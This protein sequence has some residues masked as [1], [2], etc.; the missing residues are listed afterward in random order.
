VADVNG[1]SIPDLVV[2]NS[3]SSN[4]PGGTVSVL[5]GNGNGSFQPQR[6]FDVG[7][8]PQSVVVADINGDGRPDLVTAN[9]FD[10]T[11][12]VL[13]GT[14]Q[15]LFQG[16]GGAS[17]RT[18]GPFPVGKEPSSVV[19]ADINKDGI[20]DLITANQS[21]N[22]VSVLLGNGDGT[23]KPQVSFPVGAEPYAVAVADLDGDGSLDLVVANYQDGTISVLLG[24][25]NGTFRNLD[26]V[27]VGNGPYAIGIADVNG[28]GTLDLV[29]PNYLDDTVRVLLG[30]GD[31]T[32]QDPD[33]FPVGSGPCAVQ[34]ADVNRDHKPDLLVANKKDG[35]VSVLLNK[36]RDGA[37]KLTFADPRTVLVG[38]MPEDL[39]VVDLNGDGLLDLITA[40]AADDTVSVLQGKGDGS[41]QP[42]RTFTVGSEPLGV[43]VAD[44]NGDGRPDLVT[45]NRNENTLSVLFSNGDDSFQPQHT[46][47]VGSMPD[48]LAVR[49][50]NGDGRPDLI[51]ANAYGDTVSV[52]L[53]GDGSFTPTSDTGGVEVRNTPLQADF[54]GDGLPDRVILDQAGNI[55]FREGQSSQAMPFD[56]PRVISSGNPARD[57]T[58]VHTG[59]GFAI[60]AADA[61]IDTALS[62]PG[63]LIYTLST[64][65]VG[66]GSIDQTT[67]F[68]TDLLP[69]RIAAADLTG[70]GRDDLVVLNALN[71]SITI[72]FQTGSG[73]FGSALTRS[74]DLV[75]ADV[76]FVDVNGDG[77]LDIVVCDQIS[78]DVCVLFNDPTHSFSVSSRFRATPGATATDGFGVTSNALSVS[79]TAGYFTGDQNPDLVVIN[80]GT[81]TISLLPGDAQGGFGA[82]RPAVKTIG[83]AA[84]NLSDKA[85]SVVAG[86]FNHDGILDLAVLMEDLAQVW[87]FT[88]L[89]NGKL[90]P[91]AVLPAGALPTGLSVINDSRTGRLDLLVGNPFGDILQLVGQ[92][93]GTFQPLLSFPT[94]RA[95]LDQTLGPSNQPVFLVADQQHNRVTIQ[96]PITGETRFMAKSLAMAP[97]TTLF[98]PGAVHWFKLEG[99]ASPFP[100]AVVVASGANAVLVY[101]FVQFDSSGQPTFGQTPARY[102]VGTNP[103]SVT[104][105]DLNGDGIPDLVVANEGSD[106]V[107]ILLGALDRKGHWVAL[108]GPRLQSGGA[109]PVATTLL[110]VNNDGIPD[111][112]VTNSQ[113]NTLAILPGRGLG[114]FDDR[115]PQVISVPANVGPPMPTVDPAGRSPLIPTPGGIFPLP[116]PGGTTLPPPVFTPLP[117]QRIAAVGAEPNGDLVVAFEG[118]TA[119]VLG[120]DPRTELYTVVDTLVPLAGIPSAP[121][122]LGILNLNEVVLTNADSDQ[123]FVYSLAPFPTE[124]LISPS[125]DIPNVLPVQLPLEPTTNSSSPPE[126]PLVLVVTLLASNLSTDEVAPNTLPTQEASTPQQGGD[127]EEDEESSSNPPPDAPKSRIGPDVD[128]ALRG[129]ELFRLPEEMDLPGPQA[130][131]DFKEEGNVPVVPLAVWWQTPTQ[132]HPGECDFG[133]Q[134]WIPD[135][136]L[137][138]P[139]A[140]PATSSAIPTE[141]DLPVFTSHSENTGWSLHQGPD[142]RASQSAEE[143]SISLV[144]NNSSRLLMDENTPAPSKNTLDQL[145]SAAREY[146]V[147]LVES[148]DGPWNL[149]EILGAVLAGSGFAW[150]L[151]ETQAREE[152]S[153]F[154]GLG[155][156]GRD[157]E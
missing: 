52:L 89:G 74:V 80:R 56:T 98:A 139:S 152:R 142:L 48:A 128:N 132:E 133:R 12:T 79:L 70:S 137:N 3:S 15:D 120:L 146:A 37:A 122:A 116:L 7:N 36:T 103:E 77:L 83:G 47:T 35:T 41:F 91:P 136:L 134:E 64:Y 156:P 73:H 8:Y 143:V 27:P 150:G 63:H 87:I 84:F 108:P 111:L 67:V 76:S 145:L 140:L 72:V 29:V 13:L 55:L 110:D 99:D 14:S 11:V 39:A 92:A 105:Q 153:Q 57:L 126:T 106:D 30:N 10:D 104:I 127:G 101:R 86:D 78:G 131:N 82:P 123:L 117:G 97:A 33:P 49:D 155:A 17:F 46:F 115:S 23:F 21:D 88:G 24:N 6:A 71:N 53:N 19:A 43:A 81:R 1:D 34:V 50:L 157:D 149:R 96:T 38:K 75:P 94:D 58:V 45:I 51:A 2:A 5:L 144:Q 90:A 93:D 130:W 118:G 100:D 138:L 32:F 44:L 9:T 124:P 65:T 66:D 125:Q 25:G 112:M 129:L 26:P 141:G 61:R 147:D 54:N 113:S 69:T 121:S 22:T 119:E 59:S 40:N 85:G 109:G 62:S 107:S 18:Q 102:P 95:P 154:A 31:G 28:D 42:Q 148:P 68:T 20:P 4:S 151:R 135:D 60:A 114:F 16:Q